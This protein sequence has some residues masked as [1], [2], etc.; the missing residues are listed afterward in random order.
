MSDT[1]TAGARHPIGVVVRR[2]GLSAEVIRAWEQRYGAVSPERTEG[3]QRL[4]TESDVRRLRLLAAA[5][6]AGHRIG[7]IAGL[8][9]SS[10]ETT[11]R[12]LGGALPAASGEGAPVPA[13]GAPQLVA[14]ALA[15]AASADAIGLRTL[16]RRGAVMLEPMRFIEDVIVP[17]LVGVGERWAAGEVTPAHE[18]VSSGVVRDV[19]GWLLENTSIS[20]GAPLVLVGVPAGQ[21]HEFGALLA[22]VT[23]GVAGWSVLPLGGDLPARDIAALAH[24]TGAR[25]VALSVVYAGEDATVLRRELEGLRDALGTTPLI[26]GGRASQQVVGGE[27]TLD[28]VSELRAL[29]ARLDEI[30]RAAVEE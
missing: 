3:G 20:V 22:G 6:E 14:A 17:F 4:Y 5:V 24:Q 18:H 7:A 10:L 11:V 23:A 25:A 21:R 29:R 9:A 15:A 16:L 8:S 28:Y 26:L 1:E 30:A 27:S 12:D 13:M 2:T 19:L